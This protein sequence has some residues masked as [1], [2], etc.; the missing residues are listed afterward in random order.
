MIDTIAENGIRHINDVPYKGNF[1]ISFHSKTE[2][3]ILQN[4]FNV[5]SNK[6]DMRLLEKRPELLLEL[7]RH[8]DEIIDN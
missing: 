8:K 1:T 6:F 2:L 7:I 5:R 4:F 3:L